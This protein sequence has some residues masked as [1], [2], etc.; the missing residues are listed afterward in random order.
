MLEYVE[1]YGVDI[2][3]N[4]GMRVKNYE[5]EPSDEADIK[6]SIIEHIEATGEKPSNELT[7]YLINREGEAI[8]FEISPYEY[9]SVE[10][11]DKLLEG[12]E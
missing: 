9:F 4:R 3:G 12:L 6:D 7:I 1:H 5:I 10:E 11:I 8:G 2:D